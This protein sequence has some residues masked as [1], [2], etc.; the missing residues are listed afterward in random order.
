MRNTLF[1][2]VLLIAQLSW[3]A[4]VTPA[5]QIPEYYAS[6]T[7]QADKALFDAV[8]TTAKK[9]YATLTYKDLWTAYG[10]TDLYPTDT[11][12]P[13]YEPSKAGRIWDMYSFC[14][15][16]YRTNQCGTYKSECNCYNRE[17][18]IPK[19]WFG[20]SE[21]KNTPGTDLFHV[22]PTDG[23]VNNVRGNYAFGEV[24]SASYTHD[25]CKFGSNKSISIAHTMLG[26]NEVSTSCGNNQ[27]VFEP[28]DQ[29]KGDFARG[30][31]GALLRWS[32]DYQAFTQEDGRKI[33][34]GQYTVSGHFGL[35]EYGIALLLKWH[36]QD[37]VSRKEIDR[38]NGIQSQQGNRNPFIDYPYLAEFIWG[39]KAG[40]TV[41]LNQLMASTDPDFVPGQSNGW[42]GGEPIINPEQGME[43]TGVQQSAV[44][45]Q[46]MLINGQLFIQVGE[47]IYDVTGKKIN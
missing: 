30:Y 44:K 36:R 24:A 39:E 9:G 2:A 14:T 12:H 16:T 15:F 40:E 23:Y 18:S 29:Y 37:P 17:H 10:T 47:Y 7:G 3:A 31:L 26:D 27:R 4:V 6:L 43:E 22:V 38:N 19:S 45:V 20:G 33:F 11:Q 8:H 42:R 41:Y 13:D 32:G 35:T 5:D 34:S 21:G 28:A 25:G 46:K 1:V